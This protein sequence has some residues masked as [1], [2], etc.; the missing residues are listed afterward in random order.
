LSCTIEGL[1]IEKKKIRFFTFA[2]IFSKGY[3]SVVLEAAILRAEQ[4]WYILII[5]QHA[6]NMFFY[7][8]HQIFAEF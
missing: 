7:A 6:K 1:V 3:A 5:F 2:D 8:F 4:S